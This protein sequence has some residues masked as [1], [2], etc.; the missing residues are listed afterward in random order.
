M[1]RLEVLISIVGEQDANGQ[2]DRSELLTD[3]MMTVTPDGVRLSYRESAATGMEGTDTTLTV[4]PEKV[5]LSRTGTHA[6]LLVL[7]HKRRHL[8][9][10]GTPYGDLM[11][12]VFTEKMEQEM[13]ENGGS[14]R[15]AYTLDVGGSMLSRQEL[16]V[17]VRPKN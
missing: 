12:G 10:Y 13:T 5:T 15:L 9:S 6:G 17:T 2:K 1:R 14:V 16:S 8:C 7:E 11:L 4:Q 3:G